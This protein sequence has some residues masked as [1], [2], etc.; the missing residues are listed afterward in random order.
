M[1]KLLVSWIRVGKAKPVRALLPL[2]TPSARGNVFFLIVDLSSAPVVAERRRPDH[3]VDY[4]LY[5]CAPQI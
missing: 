1:V 5:A 3:P 2:R 4:E